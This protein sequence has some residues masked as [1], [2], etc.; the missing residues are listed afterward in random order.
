MRLAQKRA[1]V[2]SG[3]DGLIF[4]SKPIDLAGYPTRAFHLF[5]N[6]IGI[7]QSK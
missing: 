7:S 5:P 3:G 6:E 1:K 4:V 2:G